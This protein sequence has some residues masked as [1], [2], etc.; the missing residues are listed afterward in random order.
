MRELTF[1]TAARRPAGG[2]LARRGR[3]ARRAPERVVLQKSILV[4]IRQLCID[5]SNKLTDLYGN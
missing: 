1:V 3:R 5:I 2:P 4:Q